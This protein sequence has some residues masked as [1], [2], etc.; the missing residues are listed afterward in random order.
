MF[1]PPR[2]K[3]SHLHMFRLGSMLYIPAYLTLPMLRRFANEE[4]RGSPIVM[5]CE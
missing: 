5:S 1:S 3:L 4:S 2:G